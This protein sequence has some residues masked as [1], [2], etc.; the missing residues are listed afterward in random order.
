[1]AEVQ[2]VAETLVALVTEAAAEVGAVAEA[3]AEVLAAVV[4]VVEAGQS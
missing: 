2:A 3:A 4:E 1:V